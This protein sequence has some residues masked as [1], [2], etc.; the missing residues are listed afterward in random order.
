MPRPL[1][2][3]PHYL[4]SAIYNPKTGTWTGFCREP[5]IASNGHLNPVDAVAGALEKTKQY[6]GEVKKIFGRPAQAIADEQLYDRTWIRFTDIELQRKLKLLTA[7]NGEMTV[8]A[9]VS[10]IVKQHLDTIDLD[11]IDW[12]EINNEHYDSK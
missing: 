4:Y 12:G 10:H 3:D 5:A 9:F 6:L 1:E 2:E 7:A 8:S 11:T